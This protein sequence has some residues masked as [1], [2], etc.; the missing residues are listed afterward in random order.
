MTGSAWCGD[1]G[2]ATCF[3][4]AAHRFAAVISI[5][6]PCWRPCLVGARAVSTLKAQ[7]GGGMGAERA[8]EGSRAGQQARRATVITFC[9]NVGSSI[10]KVCRGYRG[11]SGPV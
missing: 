1:G 5:Y 7:Y 3:L 10:M 8:R 9:R 6:I 4:G 2:P 11:G